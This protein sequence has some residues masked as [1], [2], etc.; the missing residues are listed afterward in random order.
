MRAAFMLLADRTAYTT[1]TD[2]VSDL[3]SRT[4]MGAVNDFVDYGG[5]FAM[6]SGLFVMGS[7]LQTRV[8]SKL[9]PGP[10]QTGVMAVYAV[11]ALGFWSKFAF[12]EAH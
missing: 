5:L 4:E 3:D 2:I 11:M 9:P 1:R 10:A 6:G 12:A 8:V 7:S